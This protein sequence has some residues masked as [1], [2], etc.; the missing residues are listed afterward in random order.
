MYQRLRRRQCRATHSRA[1]RTARRNLLFQYFATKVSKIKHRRT[2]LLTGAFPC[3]VRMLG[4]GPDGRGTPSIVSYFVSA[5]LAQKSR[6]SYRNIFLRREDVWSWPGWPRCWASY[7]NV[8][9]QG[10]HVWSWAGWSR[11]PLNCNLFCQQEISTDERGFLPER[12]VARCACL[13][14]GRTVEAPGF[15]PERFL[16]AWACLELDRMVEVSPWL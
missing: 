1:T 7:R 8:A 13:E 6:A 12:F 10:A 14:L 3:G 15:L 5:R 9:L 11:S 16:A 4:A 2:V